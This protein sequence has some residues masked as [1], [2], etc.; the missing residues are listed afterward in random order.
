MKTFLNEVKLHIRLPL[1]WYDK[2]VSILQL[3]SINLQE[4]FNIFSSKFMPLFEGK[5]PCTQVHLK[6]CQTSMMDFFFAK[7]S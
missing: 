7:N 2:F 3:K 5:K 4:T 6:A 1:L